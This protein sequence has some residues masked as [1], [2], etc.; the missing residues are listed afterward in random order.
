MEVRK[1][2][3]TLLQTDLQA[4]YRIRKLG[5]FCHEMSRYSWNV[6]GIS[7][8]RWLNFWE[9]TTDE[10]HKIWY[11]GEQD[12]HE[13]GMAIMVHKATTNSVI[14]WQPVSSR[15][16]TIRLSCMPQNITIVQVY[17]PT[18]NATDEKVKISTMNLK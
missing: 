17:A 18:S 15:I 10:G 8:V 4:R 12:K 16:I 9:A 7:E 2:P 5:E 14:S 1:S 6:L 11:S 13:L 3:N